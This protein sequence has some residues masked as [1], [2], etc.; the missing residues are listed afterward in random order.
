MA[1]A[2]WEANVVQ[3]DTADMEGGLLNWSAGSQASAVALSTTVG[4]NTGATAARVTYSG[5]TT[6]A[7]VVNNSTDVPVAASTAYGAAFAAYVTVAG[8]SLAIDIDW[9]TSGQGYISTT[10]TTP[11]ALTAGL[12]N[13]LPVQVVTTPAT[14]A[15]A[16]LNVRRTAGLTAGNFVYLDT[17]FVGRF[18]RAPLP[19]AVLQAPMRAAT[20]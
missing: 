20:W 15:F 11:T 6:G 7:L 3:A 14:T 1:V 10:S 5:T 2:L 19:T 8:V 4:G 17:F 16:R 12:W 18:L 9:Y 13:P